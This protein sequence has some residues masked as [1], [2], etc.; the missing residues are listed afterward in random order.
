MMSQ[1]TAGN[2]DVDAVSV[3]VIRSYE[4]FNNTLSCRVYSTVSA[5]YGYSWTLNDVIIGNSR[6]LTWSFTKEDNGKSIA[7][8]VYKYGY[9][10]GRQTTTVHIYCKSKK[11]SFD[12]QKR[13][14]HIYLDD[15]DEWYNR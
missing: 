14:I 4:H 3:D 1:L 12:D 7:C 10:I 15:I 2:D 6:N 9:K 8:H 13:C 5:P 11:E